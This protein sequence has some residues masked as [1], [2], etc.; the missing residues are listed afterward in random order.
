M[1]APSIVQLPDLADPLPRPSAVDATLTL[2][3]L[4][5]DL[6]RRTELWRPHVRFD[7][8]DRFYER[9]AGSDTFEAWLLTWIPGQSTGWHDHGGSAGAF[10]VLEGNLQER[11]LSRSLVHERVIASGEV[12]PFGAQHVHEVEPVG[13]RAVSL[14][15][16]APAP[17]SMTRYEL[18]R[19]RLVTHS[20]E[21]A[22]ADW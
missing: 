20:V 6:A 8:E 7:I 3:L 2:G 13:G 22:G 21:A 12:R 18:V 11:T 14:H 9:I 19:G 17:R 15:V 5:T 16:Y 10:T 4:A 1:T